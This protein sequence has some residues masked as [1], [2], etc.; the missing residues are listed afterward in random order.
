METTFKG[1]RTAYR[2]NNMTSK[3][4]GKWILLFAA[5]E[6][7]YW[8]NYGGYGN[9][10]VV[11]IHTSVIFLYILYNGN[12]NGPLMTT[13]LPISNKKK[14]LYSYIYLLMSMVAAVAFYTVIMLICSILNGTDR[15]FDLIT[16]NFPDTGVTLGSVFPMVQAFFIIVCSMPLIFKK[17][18]LEWYLTAGTIVILNLL[19]NIVVCTVANSGRLS[20]STSIVTSYVNIPHYRLA[21]TI[22]CVFSVC[23]AVLSYYLTLKNAKNMTDP[24][25]KSNI[26]RFIKKIKDTF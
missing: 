18:K 13:T 22:Y 1:F 8:I 25:S 21:F 24:E 3:G 2:L 20:I 6:M 10:Y 15:M 19:F 12:V 4:A 7:L 5:L 26:I 17:S 11:L 16:D 9:G 23:A 14:V